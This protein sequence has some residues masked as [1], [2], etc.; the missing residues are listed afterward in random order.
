MVLHP[1]QRV[2]RIYNA[3]IHKRLHAKNESLQ[4]AHVTKKVCQPLRRP[5]LGI[6]ALGIWPVLEFAEYSRLELRIQP[7]LLPCF[8]VVFTV[9][10]GRGD[11]LAAG[12]CVFEHV[13]EYNSSH[14]IICHVEDAAFVFRML[15]A[16]DRFH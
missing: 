10:A 5:S 12:I 14:T 11:K 16:G 8:E 1:L 4:Y 7:L 15:K 3:V 2:S 13:P 9:W 6:P